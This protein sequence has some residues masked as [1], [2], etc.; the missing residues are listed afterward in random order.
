MKNVLLPLTNTA[1]ETS[2]NVSGLGSEFRTEQIPLGRLQLISGR[3]VIADP[4]L[5]MT[6]YDNP[7]LVTPKGTFA[8]YLTRIICVEKQ[9]L[10]IPAYLSIIFDAQG[11]KER[12]EEQQHWYKDNDH[13]TLR[14]DQYS[15]LSL[16][17]EGVWES[18]EDDEETEYDF[19]TRSGMIGLV[20]AQSLEN[21]M[22]DPAF[23]SWFET[24]F[25]P[26]SDQN[27]TKQ[28]DDPEHLIEGCANVVLPSGPDDWDEKQPPTMILAQLAD[29]QVIPKLILE[30]RL[31]EDRH[32]L[33]PLAFHIDFGIMNALQKEEVR[34][35]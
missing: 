8:V 26:V 16:T 19:E 32:R 15:F 11:L 1:F 31:D 20:D 6:S 2:H 18:I 23:Q 9:E 12:Q 21:R 33:Y 14:E 13:M 4:I 28:V 35:L 22:P 25:D 10:E 29:Q 7:Y 24:F 34:W 30:W 3:L 17:H 27:W 5:G